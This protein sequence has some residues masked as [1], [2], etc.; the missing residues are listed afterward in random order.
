MD[1]GQ[2]K[3]TTKARYISKLWHSSTN[4]NC[5]HPSDRFA[6]DT[7]ARRAMGRT[8]DGVEPW[9]TGHRAP[10]ISLYQSRKAALTAD[11]KLGEKRVES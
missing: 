1:P 3:K 5:Y 8:R 9:F 10:A 6:G 11:P 4:A 7:E 2:D